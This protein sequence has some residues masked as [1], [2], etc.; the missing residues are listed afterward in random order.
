M[1]EKY[2]GLK[3]I[4]QIVAHITDDE[5]IGYVTPYRKAHI[6]KIIVNHKQNKGK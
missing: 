1:L 4:N 5:C 3:V 2:Y 6:K